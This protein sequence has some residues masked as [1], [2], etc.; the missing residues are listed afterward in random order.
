MVNSCSRES[1][2]PLVG[3]REI[4]L[5]DDCA[6]PAKIPTSVK[7]RQMW[8]TRFRFASELLDV[9]PVQDD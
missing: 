8:G 4:L 5:Y 2:A 7:N 3:A 1:R 9:N 6:L